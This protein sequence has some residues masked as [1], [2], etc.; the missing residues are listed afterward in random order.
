MFS[1]FFLLCD[2]WYSIYWY[3]LFRTINNRVM[4]SSGDDVSQLM[5]N[6]K[7]RQVSV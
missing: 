5:I 2:A 7:V 1:C 3:R 4:T 6:D